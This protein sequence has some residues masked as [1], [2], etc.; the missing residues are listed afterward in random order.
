MKILLNGI[1]ARSAGGISVIINL[2]NA[3]ASQKSNIQYDL[4]LPKNLDRDNPTFNSSI[5]VHYKKTFLHP[6]ISRF[7]DLNYRINKWCKRY[8]SDICFTMGD[9]GPINMKIPHIVLLQQAIIVYK[10]IEYEKYWSF[11]EKKKYNFMRRH[12]KKMVKK[13]N[14][15]TVQTPVM[16]N[17]VINQFGVDQDK[18]LIVPSSLP[19]EKVVKVSESKKVQRIKKMNKKFKF[20]FLAAGYSHKNHII[21]P[22]VV[23]ELKR[24]DIDNEVHF[25]I[26]LDSNS[27]GYNKFISKTIR[28]F[29][30]NITNLGSLN[31]AEVKGAY[32][33]SSALFLP[34]FV[35]SFG[36][37]YLEAMYY[38]K[39]VITSDKDFARWICKDKA[40]YFDPSDPIS[41]T[42]TIQGFIKNK[43][44]FRILVENDFDNSF[45]RTWDM[46]ASDYIKIFKTL[47]NKE[48]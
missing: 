23:S 18:I 16:K 19:K 8:N 20:L 30:Q 40:F 33:Y 14:Y 41:I 15:L 3:L 47:I 9:I 36:L 26:T 11:V 7:L 48:K 22:E 28:G 37:I 27:N 38:K 44:K 4:I 25:F 17:K 6:F 45:N 32:K 12:F 35:E 10:D 21:L 5:N 46:A 24:R 39:P 31:S 29:E 34:T 42:D 2:V 13:C 43:D 1:N